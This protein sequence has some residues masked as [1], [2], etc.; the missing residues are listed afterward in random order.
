MALSQSTDTFNSRTLPFCG[1][2]IKSAKGDSS[3]ALAQLSLWLSAGVRKMKELYDKAHTASSHSYSRPERQS[4]LEEPPAAISTAPASATHSD[5][6]KTELPPLLGW[7][8]LAHEWRL[9]AAWIKDC[10]TSE[11]V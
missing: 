1:L 3:E 7:T 5:L 9:Y 2:E 6:D 10:S 8:V 11:T 4:G